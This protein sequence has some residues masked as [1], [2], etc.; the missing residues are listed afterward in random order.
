MPTRCTYNGIVRAW[1]GLRRSGDFA[2]VTYTY[3]ILLSQY[4]CLSLSTPTTSQLE[5]ESIGIHRLMS[6]AERHGGSRRHSSYTVSADCHCP[7]LQY[8]AGYTYA[9]CADN[10]REPK[11]ILRIPKNWRRVPTESLTTRALAIVV[12]LR[13]FD[14]ISVPNEFIVKFASG[15]KKNRF[16]ALLFRFVFV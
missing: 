12:C 15:V 13:K 4:T 10:G 7:P 16:A 3:I 9:T 2:E 6:A 11:N 1:N 5:Y 8:T 14:A